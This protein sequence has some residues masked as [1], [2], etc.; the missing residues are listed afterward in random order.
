MAETK[1]QTLVEKFMTEG[2]A[3]LKELRDQIAPLEKERDQLESMLEPKAAEAPAPVEPTPAPKIAEVPAPAAAK[4]KGKRNR[5]GGTREEHF[6]SLV[7]EK[8]GITVSEA[9]KEM[10]IQPNYLYRVAAK[11]LEAGEV[12]QNEKKGYVPA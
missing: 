7:T 2:K 3:R 10:K 12:K 5:K 9:A 4:P 6:V 11:C 1:S 8:P